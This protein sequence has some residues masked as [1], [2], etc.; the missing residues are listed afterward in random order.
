MEHTLA[1]REAV[2]RVAGLSLDEIRSFLEGS[3]GIILNGEYGQAINLA[4]AVRATYG[5]TTGAGSK[6]SQ[7]GIESGPSDQKPTTRGFTF[8]EIEERSQILG[9]A[10]NGFIGET[11]Q[12]AQKTSSNAHLA[13]QQWLSASERR[14]LWIY[15]SPNTS[16]P[17]DLSLTSA[18]VVSTITHAKLPLIAHQCQSSESE[19]GSL[20]SLV[21]SVVIQLIWLLPE[22]FSTDKDFGSERFDSL[23]RSRESLPRALCLM[24]DLFTLA[25]RLLIVV[26]DGIQMCEDGLDRERGTGMYVSF[27][28]EILKNGGNDRVLKT[29]FTTDGVCD[30]FWLKLSPQEQVDVRSETGGTPGHRRKGRVAMVDLVTIRD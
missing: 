8:T 11:L 28:R 26:I 6:S 22:D 3:A 20:I 1:S 14:V 24:E 4:N 27:F 16:K 21:Y 7:E 19:M 17:S 23:D 29:L 12:S 5:L 13:L 25:P 9:T 15:G 2:E 30:N 18:F 10:T